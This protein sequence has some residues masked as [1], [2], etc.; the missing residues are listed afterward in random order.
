LLRNDDPTLHHITG[1]V[2]FFLCAPIQITLTGFS[3]AC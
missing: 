2:I 1:A 3:I